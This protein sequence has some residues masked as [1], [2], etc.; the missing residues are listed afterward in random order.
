MLSLMLQ[1]TDQRRVGASFGTSFGNSFA[2]RR[3]FRALVL[4][5][6]AGRFL[7]LLFSAAFV[8]FSNSPI[9][10]PLSPSGLLSVYLNRHALCHTFFPLSAHFSTLFLLSHFSPSR[11]PRPLT[12]PS[13]L[14]LTT[15]PVSSLDLFFINAHSP[16]G[17]WVWDA[18]GGISMGWSKTEAGGHPNRRGV[19]TQKFCRNPRTTSSGC[20]IYRKNC[21][22]RPS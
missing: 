12:D 4:F 10:F 9:T 17:A 11:S 14:I 22:Q 8:G 13:A 6:A 3:F 18:E 19:A 2:T 5:S 1:N 20:A 21:I 15:A 16:S 7:L